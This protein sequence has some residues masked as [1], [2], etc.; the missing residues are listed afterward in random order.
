MAYIKE[1]AKY[2]GQE[3]TIKGWLY[4][5]R[6]SG[7][8]YFLLIRDGTGI[9]QG[10][11]LEDNVSKKT[12]ELCD[13][14]TQESSIIVKGK[15][16]KDS[17]APGGYE[18][19]L[20]DIKVVQLTESYPISKKT[21]GIDFLL[22]NRHLWLR[23]RRQYAILKVRAE[24][25]RA[26]NDF[27]DSRGFLRFDAPILTPSS[28]EGTTTL[29]EVPY[30]DNKVY[31]S[32]SGQLYAEAGCMAFGK[33]YTFGPTF[34]AELSKTKRHITEFWQIEPEVAYA[35]LDDIMKL[36]EEFVSYIVK[37]VLDK[38]EEELSIL[39]RDT[40][41]LEKI[42]LP[43]SRITY[44]E[45]LNLLDKQTEA[46][47]LKWGEDLGAPQE[48]YL[49]NQFEVPFFIHH[50]PASC[51][52]FY[53]KR[54]PENSEL[55]LCIDMLAPEGYGEIMTGSERE[56]NL[57]ILEQRLKEF[58]LPKKPQEWYLDLRRYGSVPHSGFGLGLERTIAWLCGLKHIRE[59]IPFPRTID[60]AYP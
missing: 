48:T 38:R 10:L 52:A 53:M 20:N 55:S 28:C 33:V 16:R 32:Q 58:N 43:F 50:Y 31:L 34:R 60:R 23:S 17:R 5:K 21:H 30:F 2:E 29:F 14:L 41:L 54:D 45:A 37:R 12:F 1:I 56:D 36:A 13:R 35:N 46:P 3:I 15:V 59:A 49:A 40:K 9:I 6:S 24:V 51:K 18:L 42:K 19:E 7:K 47:K 26:I 44:K 22:S 4:N 25:I 57:K 27:F 8:I 11:V 39:E